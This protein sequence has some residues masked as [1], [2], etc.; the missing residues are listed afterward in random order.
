MESSVSAGLDRETSG[1]SSARAATM[2][3]PKI[4]PNL[5]PVITPVLPDNRARGRLCGA[6][7]DNRNRGRLWRNC[8]FL[9]RS[10]AVDG[11]NGVR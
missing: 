5:D 11:R 9:A 3:A 6:D 7:V 2:T 8:Q 1:A 10:G 4:A